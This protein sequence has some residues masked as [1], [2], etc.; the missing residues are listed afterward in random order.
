MAK[1]RMELQTAVRALVRQFGPKFTEYWDKRM[2]S[3]QHLTCEGSPVRG[4][5]FSPIGHS[6]H[7]PQEDSDLFSD[8][9]ADLLEST[10]Y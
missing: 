6:Y 10:N 8:L 5:P 4:F 7:L 9:A 3:D 1:R 2:V